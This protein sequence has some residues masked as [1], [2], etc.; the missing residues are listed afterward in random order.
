MT[1]NRRI[2]LTLLRPLLDTATRLA[3]ERRQNLG[4]FLQGAIQSATEQERE[5]RITS[6][7]RT[8]AADLAAEFDGAS[9][10]LDLQRRLRSRGFVLRLDA[11]GGLYLHVWPSDRRLLPIEAMDHSLESLSQH[12]RAVFPGASAHKWVARPRQ[13]RAA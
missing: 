6:A 5:R 9:N 4:A 3:A 13:G 1:Q 12:F 8:I 10:W 2:N 7:T 11:A